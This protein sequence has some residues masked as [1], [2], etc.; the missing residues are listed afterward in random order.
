MWKL[1][2]RTNMIRDILSWSE[3]NQPNPAL[4]CIDICRVYFSWNLYAVGSFYDG[5]SGLSRGASIGSVN[6]TIVLSAAVI[7]S[8]AAHCR[9]SLLQYPQHGSGLMSTH[10]LPFV[11]H[12]SG[13]R[14]I[15]PSQSVGQVTLVSPSSHFPFPQQYVRMGSSGD[16]ST[17]NLVWSHEVFHL[18]FVLRQPAVK[19]KS[20]VPVL[21]MLLDNMPPAQQKFNSGRSLSTRLGQSFGQFTQFSLYWHIPSPQ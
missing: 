17:I 3:K 10:L 18:Q 11:I 16:H 7:F 5:G 19:F 4:K 6:P 21:W 1:H 20:P 9:V 14:W 12:L 8:L 15:K 13:S 2:L